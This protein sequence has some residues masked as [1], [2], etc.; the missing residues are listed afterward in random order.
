MDFD[1]NLN[2]VEQYEKRLKDFDRRGLAYATRET[3]NQAAF[4]GRAQMQREIKDRFI[5]RNKWTERSVQVN[6]AKGLDID[7]QASEMGSVQP[8]MVTQEEGGQ[9]RGRNGDHSIPTGYSAGQDGASKRTRNVRK[10]NRMNSIKLRK[11]P[12][13]KGYNRGHTNFLI[14]R[15][16]AEERIK[17]IYL[18]TGK[19]RGVYRV[20]GGKRKPKIRMVSDLSRKSVKIPST[21]TLEPATRRTIEL[22][23]FFYFKA[24][25][26]QLK[27]R[28]LI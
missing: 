23:D 16:A 11:R 12:R 6:K 28:K 9:I 15:Q 1:A 3:L 18:D 4:Y 8:Y 5:N 24:L 2:L 14:V 13:V 10:A 17:F 25:A 21:K 7:L 22:M 20:L 19:S 27:R 26:F